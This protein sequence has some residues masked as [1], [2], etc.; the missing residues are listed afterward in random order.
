MHT[1]QRGHWP[2]SPD[3]IGL[4]RHL[5]R[6]ASQ[7]GLAGTRRDDLLLAANEAVINVL[8]HGDAAGTV[9]VWRDEADLVVD[10][11]DDAGR[12]AP[13]QADHR[14]PTPGSVRGFGLWL[15][16]RLCDEFTICQSGGQSRVR[17][18]MHLHTT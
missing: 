2:I 10:V 9:S 12:L 18:R 14:R 3:L 11:V 5:H 13:D 1:D 17:L 8:E 16:G 4:R 15:M 6:Y 7:V